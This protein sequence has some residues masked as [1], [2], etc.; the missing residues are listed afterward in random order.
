MHGAENNSFK[1]TLSIRVRTSLRSVVL[2]CIVALSSQGMRFAGAQISADEYKVEAAFVFHF[3]QLVDWPSNA[4][5]V[6][7]ESFNVCLLDVEP[8]RQELQSTLEGKPIGSRTMHVRLLD[9]SQSAENCNILFL[10]RNEGR[11]QDEFLRTLRGQ[12]VLTIGDADSFLTDGGII[13][14]HLEQNKVRFDI[15]AGAAESCHLKISSRLLLLA[16][17]VTYSGSTRGG[18]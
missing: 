1:K 11:R 15:N 13:R 14:F 12:P 7:G 2:L 18:N 10:S 5:D 6:R 17:S 9:K 16:T 8:H 4:L 3:A